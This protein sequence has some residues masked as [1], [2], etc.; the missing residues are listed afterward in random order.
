MTLLKKQQ[1]RIRRHARIRTRIQGTSERPRLSIFRSARH[2]VAQLVDDVN[3]ITIASSS[4]LGLKKGTKLEQAEMV[5]KEIAQKAQEKK[6]ITIVCDRGG[7]A[8]HGRVK[9][10]AEAARSAGLEF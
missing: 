8:Y 6:I 9:A 5:G 7:Y 2:I 3:G 1:S 10:V 4:T